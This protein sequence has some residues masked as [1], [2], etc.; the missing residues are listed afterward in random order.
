[1]TNGC[2]NFIL[3]ATSLLMAMPGIAQEQPSKIIQEEE[4]SEVFLE[5][6]TDKFEETFFEALKQKGIENY[7][8]AINLLLECKALEPFDATIDHELAKAYYADKKYITAQEYAENALTKQPDNYWFLNTWV[9]SVE[10][11]SNSVDALKTT[12][13]YDNVVLRENLSF[14]YFKNGQYQKA[15]KELKKLP[16]SRKTEELR[17]KIQDS[18]QKPKAVVVADNDAKTKDKVVEL[19]PADSLKKKLEG[20]IQQKKFKELASE[21]EE[22]MEMY[23]LQPFFYYAN[24]LALNNLKQHA[25]AI[26]VLETAL[27][28]L[29]DDDGLYDVIYRQLANAHNA[30]GNSS[31]ANEY[32]SKLK[33]GS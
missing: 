6:Y 21:S 3:I 19:N 10:K 13:P 33:S 22:A 24:G 30:L 11:Q 2:K 16:K 28:Y 15:L 32:L 9:E 20:Y 25:Q 12:L 31:K 5:E 8:R 26:Q 23:P 7:D 1:M 4:S 14:I 27:D 18:L 17:N 29:F